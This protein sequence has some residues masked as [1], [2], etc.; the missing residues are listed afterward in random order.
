GVDD[1]RQVVLNAVDA[2]ARGAEICTGARCVRADRGDIWRLVVIDRGRRR[3][4][5][6]RA[7][8]VAAGAWS[9]TA[10]EA[11]L[12]VPAPR[13][14]ATQL[15]QIVFRRMFVSDNGNGLQHSCRRLI[16]RS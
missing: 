12:R 5:T 10:T 13:A 11:I 16:L 8:G 6:A 7:L 2:A 9:L 15:N 3:V 1:S 14:A 4:F